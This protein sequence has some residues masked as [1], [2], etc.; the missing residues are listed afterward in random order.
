MQKEKGSQVDA[1]RERIRGRWAERER[2]TG[3]WA[4]RER[5]TSRCRKR[6]DHSSLGDAERERITGKMWLLHVV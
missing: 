3:R 2:I 6:T 1:E 5:I 4:E